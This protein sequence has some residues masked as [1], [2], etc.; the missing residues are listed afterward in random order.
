MAE[1]KGI[2]ESGSADEVSSRVEGE[3][4]G[5]DGPDNKVDENEENDDEDGRER[6]VLENRRACMIPGQRRLSTDLAF[7]V[8]IE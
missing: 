3:D 4:E 6:E 2:G 7:S 5:A 8:V 1:T